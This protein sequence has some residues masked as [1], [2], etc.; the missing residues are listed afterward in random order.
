MEVYRYHNLY[1]MKFI[2][3]SFHLLA[4]WDC[5]GG[6]EIDF[7]KVNIMHFIFLEFNL[8]IYPMIRHNLSKYNLYY[9]ELF[10]N[11]LSDTEII[12]CSQLIL[13]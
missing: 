12:S 4:Y 11:H 5:G 6:V 2:L 9:I 7:F 10:T 13:T 3:S 1:L 8:N